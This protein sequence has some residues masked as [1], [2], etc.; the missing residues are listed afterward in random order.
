MIKSGGNIKK[1]Q[2]DN[3]FNL[4]GRLLKEKFK[5]AMTSKLASKWWNATYSLI[6]FGGC[7]SFFLLIKNISD[8]IMLDF[9]LSKILEVFLWKIEGAQFGRNRSL[10]VQESSYSEGHHLPSEQ[11]LISWSKMESS[12]FVHI[13]L[14][15]MKRKQVCGRTIVLNMFIRTRVHP[16]RVR[17]SYQ[18]CMRLC[19]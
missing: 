12:A 5:S 8:A 11:I 10:K 18:Q 19:G 7:H 14:T 16:W 2:R 3:V 6:I 9:I 17:G 1:R 13:H 4:P 15:K